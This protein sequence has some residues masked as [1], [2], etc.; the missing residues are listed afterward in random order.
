MIDN[1]QTFWLHRALHW[2][3]VLLFLGVS[4]YFLISAMGYR[5]LA[6]RLFPITVGW[7]AT[8]L[9][10]LEILRLII[11]RWLP[12]QASA[13]KTVAGDIEAAPE[14][15]TVT[16]YLASLINLAWFLMLYGLI[17]LVGL[18]WAAPLWI[19]I[20]LGA[21][22]RVRWWLTGIMMLSV[23][24]FINALHSILNLRWPTGLLSF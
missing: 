2:A 14:E 8:A 12:G 6:A 4:L 10:T 22:Y 15:Q 24:L 3:V 18:Q 11:K 21:Y 16:F 23:W 5:L 13:N 19:G 20:W 17:A 9:A 7:F 1:H